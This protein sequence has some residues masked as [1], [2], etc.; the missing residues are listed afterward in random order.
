MDA[1]K[2]MAEPET[3]GQAVIGTFVRD[4]AYAATGVPLGTN[5]VAPPVPG[6]TGRG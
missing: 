1:V 3:L 2:A 4:P 5:G 6:R